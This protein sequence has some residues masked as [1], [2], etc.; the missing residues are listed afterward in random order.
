MSHSTLVDTQHSPEFNDFVQQ[1]DI[2][3]IRILVPAHKTASVVIPIET[4][5]KIQ[6]LLAD[7]TNHP[8]LIH[9]NKGKVSTLSPL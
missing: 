4:I 8:L 7:K 3:H 9:C 1:G 5:L 6:G 2:R